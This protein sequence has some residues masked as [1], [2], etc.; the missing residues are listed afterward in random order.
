MAGDQ[1]ESDETPITYSISIRPAAEAEI[2][3]AHA[4]YEHGTEGLGLE[5]MRAVEACLAN[6]ERHPKA[7]PIVHRE[8]RRAL[9]RR[10]PYALFYL[11][12]GSNIVVIACFHASR[13]PKEWQDRD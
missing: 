11:L 3:E 6:I 8:L 10:F 13:D 1:G 2:L 12:D 7:Y 9:L 4:W 5:F